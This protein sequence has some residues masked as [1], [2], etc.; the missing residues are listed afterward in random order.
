MRWL[1][2]LMLVLL[3]GPVAAAGLE[4][5]LSADRVAEGDAL[6]LT[7]SLDASQATAAP[8]ISALDKDFRILGT[9][10]GQQVQIVNGQRSDRLSWTITL[11]PRHSGTLTI[12]AIPAGAA[13][14]DP[15]T[16]EV[17]AAADL[18][19]AD[20]AGRPQI[21][22]V[23]PP[24]TVHA[25]QQVPVTL[26]LTLPEG[27]SNGTLQVPE[28]KGATL[29]AVGK[30]RVSE[31]QRGGQPVRI[32][33]R[34]YLLRPEAEGPLKLGAFTLSGTMP[35]PGRRADPFFGGFM[36]GIDPFQPGRP[37]SVSTEPLVLDVAPTPVG[38]DGWALPAREVTIR[39]DWSADPGALQVGQAVTRTVTVTALGASAVQIPDIAVGAAAGVRIYPDGTE[40]GTVPGPKGASGERVFR[41]SVVPTAGGTAV[42][43][44]IALDWYDTGAEEARQAVLP[45][46]TLTISGP[47]AAPSPLPVAEPVAPAVEAVPVA[48][49]APPP[50]AIWLGGVVAL[51]LAAGLSGWMLLLR[52]RRA[53][54]QPT[55]RAGGETRA[56]AA[57]RA[58][59]AAKAGDAAGC[60]RAALVW[61]RQA[62]PAAVALDPVWAGLE[63]AA[64][65]GD[66]GW[67]GA[68][69]ARAM[70]KAEAG[71]A[72]KRPG[73]G[74]PP[75]YPQGV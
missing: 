65:R 41:F 46:V 49:A 16:L 66:A 8:D 40:N 13:S 11:S 30:D 2:V 1:A 9:S 58:I 51:V 59:R 31:G 75:L 21:E 20:Q 67:D 57:V 69:F 63:R 32:V 35:A 27:F 43:P 26:R 64:M 22:L 17:V 42:L 6:T 68:V 14:S 73:S 5:Q 56:A 28:V 52:R 36:G 45:A 24:G 37:V 50:R 72:G 54:R 29:E 48:E 71:L 70:A 15:L 62:G 33:E 25:R 44:A 10:S 23:A 55:P 60:Y 19:A 53:G 4:A 74:L 3:A 61:R 39:D 47:A 12:P 38:A 34:S 18:P 7:L